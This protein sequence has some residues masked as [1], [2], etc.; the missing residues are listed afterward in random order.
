MS[1]TKS[2]FDAVRLG[3]LSKVESLLQA[4]CTLVSARDA[5]GVSPVLAATYSGRREI[6]D[7][8][9][10]RGAQ[11]EIHDAAAAGR[12]D[13]VKELVERNPAQAKAFSPDGFPVVALAAVFGHHEVVR[14]L[15]EKGA[16]VNA[17]ASNGTGYNALTGSVT[18]GHAEIVKWLLET[19]AEP[20][21]RY[22]PGY[23]PLL[24]A[25]ANGR[26][27]IVKLLLTHGADPRATSNDGKSALSL[28]T[29]HN[30]P[31]VA[32]FLR[33]PSAR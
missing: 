20:N 4:D 33:S 24:A 23:T 3:D 10:A 32:E 31:H 9:L 14:Y 11:L 30:H 29:E 6:R 7:L 18:G 27:E 2:F 19:G 21:Y 25:A 5:S 12:L 26:L 1:D 13:R 8:L 22:G 15:A 28:S 16:D 17:V